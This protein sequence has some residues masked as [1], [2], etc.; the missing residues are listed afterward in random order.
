MVWR[1]RLHDFGWSGG[2]RRGLGD[3]GLV[4]EAL[5][6]LAAAGV[7]CRLADVIRWRASIE[8]RRGEEKRGEERKGVN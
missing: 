1:K 2:G 4:C 3:R 8:E 6:I 5:G 7:V